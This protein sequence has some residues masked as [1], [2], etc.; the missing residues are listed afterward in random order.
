MIRVAVLLT[1]AMGIGLAVGCR[2][3]DERR[4]STPAGSVDKAFASGGEAE[5]MLESGS[6]DV[7]PSPD[8]QIHVQWDAASGKEARVKVTVNGRVAEVRTENT[9][10]NFHVTIAVPTASNLYVRMTAGELTV[11]AVKGN[12]DIEV[13]A[14]NVTVNVGKSSEWSQVEA[15]VTT[16]NLQ[17]P[18]FQSNNSGL[19]QSLHWSGPGQYRLHASLTA[20][21]LRLES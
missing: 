18:A 19:F 12:K 13:K 10:E 8:N 14:G 1:L 20:G 21:N 6:Y 9:P 16:G 4:G 11:G 3:D 5:L 7:K 15:S 2:H 17:A